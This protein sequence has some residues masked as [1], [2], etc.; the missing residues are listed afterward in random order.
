VQ[1]AREEHAADVEDR[2]EDDRVAGE[3]VDVLDPE[4]AEIGVRLG[5]PAGDAGEADQAEEGHDHRPAG[6]VVAEMA[7][8]A[9][10]R[11]GSEIREDGAGTVD[12]I[13]EAR[14][15]RAKE[16]PGD[17]QQRERGRG[18][19]NRHVEVLRV[20]GKE[21]GEDQGGDGPMQDPHQRVPHGERARAARG[22]CIGEGE[23]AHRTTPPC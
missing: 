16:A 19:A 13:A 23:G 12:E 20:R 8:G 7:R 1:E 10:A 22:A 6:R 2:Q 18:V 9:E 21:R 14:V 15:A 3:G 4:D 5:E 11:E 17:P